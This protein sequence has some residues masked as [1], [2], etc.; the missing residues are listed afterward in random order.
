MVVNILMFV[1]LLMTGISG[2]I[3]ISKT[4]LNLTEKSF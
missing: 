3:K 2:L 4:R 1:I